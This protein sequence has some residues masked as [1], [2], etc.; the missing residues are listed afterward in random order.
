M[1]LEFL[2]ER[3]KKWPIC[4]I[5]FLGNFLG[6]PISDHYLAMGAFSFLPQKMMT[7]LDPRKGKFLTSG[8]R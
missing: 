5:V 1:G 6:I 2:R 4:W 7:K 3:K 8:G